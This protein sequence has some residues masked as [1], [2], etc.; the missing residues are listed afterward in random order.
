MAPKSIKNHQKSRKVGPKLSKIWPRT[1]LGAELVPL[2]ALRGARSAPGSPGSEQKR[3]FITFFLQFGAM[4]GRFGGPRW[5]RQGVNKSCFLV[6]KRKIT[7]K[8]SP[9]EGFEK[10]STKLKNLGFKEI[11]YAETSSG[12]PFAMHDTRKIFGHFLEIYEPNEELTNF[13]RMVEESSR[14]GNEK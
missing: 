9:G 5:G 11:L 14:N 2:G 6:K 8:L 3:A 10:A 12:F 1:V 7:G 4:F 13:Y